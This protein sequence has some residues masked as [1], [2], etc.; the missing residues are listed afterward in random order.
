MAFKFVLGLALPEYWGRP[1]SV[2]SE[3]FINARAWYV[4]ALPLLLAGVALVR[5]GRERWAVAGAAL[6]SLLVATGVD[7]LFTIAHHV[8]G[9]GQAH[10]TRLGVFVALGLALLAGWG[11]DDLVRGRRWGRSRWLPPPRW[12]RPWRRR[13]SPSRWARRLAG[14]RRGG[15]GGVGCSPTPV[16]PPRCC[17]EPRC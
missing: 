6:V 5:G 4:G 7:P 3:P 11:L 16:R 15:P 12:R 10:N 17:R 1:T 8:P 13:W 14:P 2:I 9:F